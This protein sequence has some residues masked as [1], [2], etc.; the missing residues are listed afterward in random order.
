MLNKADSQ[1]ALKKLFRRFPVADLDTLCKTLQ[2][3]SRMSIFR[4]LREIGYFSSYTHTGRYYTL[5]DVPQFDDYGLWIHQGIGFSQFGTLRATIVQLV[6]KSPTGHTHMELNNLLRIRIHNTLLKLV[7]EDRVGRKY[8]EK[9][10]LY[11]S[12]DSDHAAEQIS[13]RRVQLADSQKAIPHIATTT[14]I[15]V[16]IETIHAGQVRIAPS[17]VVKGLSARGI[18]ITVQQVEQVFSRYGID[19][20]KKTAGS[21]STFSRA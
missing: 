21:G 6:N 16:L 10:F 4:R 14:V 12:A 5:A 19:T 9:I 8:I 3:S 17:L 11:V 2:T 15:E 13:R 20:E 1:K 7:R 18:P